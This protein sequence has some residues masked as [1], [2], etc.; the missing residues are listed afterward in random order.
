MIALETASVSFQEMVQV[1]NKLVFS[2]SRCDE[3]AGLMRLAGGKGQAPS[4]VAWFLN[5]VRFALAF[6]TR[7]V[8]L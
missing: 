6:D 3:Y 7:D 4:L 5:K 8:A 2:L 1:R